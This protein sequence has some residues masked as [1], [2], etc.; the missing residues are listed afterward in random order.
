MQQIQEKIG[1][2]LIG[3]ESKIIELM[4]HDLLMDGLNSV[5]NSILKGVIPGGGSALLQAA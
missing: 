1:I 3:G 5:K 2:F 4:N